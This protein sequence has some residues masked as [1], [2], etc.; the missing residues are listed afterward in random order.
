MAYF[1]GRL[2]SIEP[3]IHQT[4]S[5]VDRFRR[6]IEALHAFLSRM[7]VQAYSNTSGHE[8]L[9]AERL[10]ILFASPGWEPVKKENQNG[11]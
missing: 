5:E 11:G 10:E 7:G 1:D 3:Y 4:T 6:E 8:L 2:S 9:L